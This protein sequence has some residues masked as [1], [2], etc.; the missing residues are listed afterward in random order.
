MWECW[1]KNHFAQHKDEHLTRM[2]ILG[3]G[4]SEAFLFVVLAHRR[5]GRHLWRRVRPLVVC[6]NRIRM[7]LRFSDG[8]LDLKFAMVMVGATERRS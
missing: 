1:V 6:V 5:F 2:N 4:V 7:S 3:L 8:S